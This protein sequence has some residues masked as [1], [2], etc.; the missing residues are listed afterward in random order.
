MSSG[1][2]GSSSSVA[3]TH[4]RSGRP[5]R[6]IGRTVHAQARR[7]PTATGGVVPVA[8]ADAASVR[9][10]HGTAR[11]GRRRGRP[12]GDDVRQHGEPAATSEESIT[13]SVQSVTWLGPDAD[14]LPQQVEERHA[15]AADD[16]VRPPDG[17]RPRSCAPRP[18]PSAGRATGPTSRR[19]RRG[20]SGRRRRPG[21]A[22]RAH[23]G[24]RAGSR[25]LDDWADDTGR[26]QIRDMADERPSRAAGVVEGP[27][28]GPA[29]PPCCATTRAPCSGSTGCRPTVR[30]EARDGLPRLGPRRHR[31]Q[32]HRGQARRAS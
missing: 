22:G 10:R 19:R 31:D 32:Q 20:S 15:V 26:L 13:S 6:A 12:V 28:R 25:E 2:S 5:S 21:L 14:A 29:A 7:D 23:R 24:R 4:A 16:G 17:A 18:R 30:A 1:P 27:H 8:G 9:S 11:G 3:S